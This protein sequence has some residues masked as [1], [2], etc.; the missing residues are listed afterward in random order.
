MEA[1]ERLLIQRCCQ[2]LVVRAAACADDMDPAGLS[3]LFT[4]GATLVRPN[5][6]PISGRDAI[7]QA[8]EKRPKDRITRHLITNTL[9]KV[10]SNMS[11]SARSYVLLW[12]GS[13]LS[14]DGPRGRQADAQKQVGEFEDSFLLSSDGEWLIH[15][16][17]ARFVLRSE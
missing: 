15:Q 2:D 4:P 3:L 5:E 1:I 10:E 9:V 13:K 12:T 6:S 14:D 16:R 8:Y 7:R 17:K 11:A